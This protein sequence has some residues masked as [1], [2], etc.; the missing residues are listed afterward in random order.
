MNHLHVRQKLTLLKIECI[1][2]VVNKNLFYYLGTADYLVSDST[3]YL[4]HLIEDLLHG[5]LLA[6]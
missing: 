3:R 6:S 4:T 1:G 5:V 2:L